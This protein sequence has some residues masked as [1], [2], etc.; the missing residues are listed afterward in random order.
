MRKFESGTATPW[1][2]REASSFF[3]GTLKRSSQIT[4]LAT[5]RFAWLARMVAASVG[6]VVFAVC[7]KAADI[8]RR[9]LSR[10][11]SAVI[12]SWFS[13]RSAPGGLIACACCTACA[14]R[15]ASPFRPLSDV[16]HLDAGLRQQQLELRSDRLRVGRDLLHVAHVVLVGRLLA[17]AAAAIDHEDQQHDDHDEADDEADQAQQRRVVGWRPFRT[18]RGPSERRPAA[19]FLLLGLRLLEKVEIDLAVALAHAASPDDCIAL[20]GS[21]K[22]FPTRR[23]RWRP[24]SSVAAALPRDELVLG[25][26]RPVQPLGSGGSGSVWL[27]RDELEGDEVTLKIVARE[28]KAAAA[29]RARARGRRAARPRALPEGQRLRNGRRPLVHRVRVRARRDVPPRPA[30]RPVGRRNYGGSRRA[31]PRRARARARARHRP[32][33]HQAVEHPARGRRGR[34]LRPPARL[35]PGA[36]RRGRHAH[37]RRRCPRHARLHLAGAPQGPDGRPGR[38]RLGRRRPALGVA[39]RLP[40]VLDIVDAGHGQ[41]D[42][43]RAALARHRAPRS[44]G[45]ADRDRRPGDVPRPAQAPERDADGG[46]RTQ[47]LAEPPARAPPEEAAATP[48]LP[49]AARG[50]H[51][52]RRARRD[53]ER[54][55]RRRRCP[56][57]RPAGPG[58]PPQSPPG[59]RSCATAPG[60]RSRSPCPCSRSAT[61]RW[62]SPSPTSPRR[63]SGW[64]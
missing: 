24:V 49:H 48:A 35:R 45:P 22:D 39:R 6:L 1:T 26:Y 9:P 51:R 10:S 27:A 3:D 32:P 60:S 33:R 47:R 16:G 8:P 42:P 56:S 61:S 13:V 57:S 50:P 55:G 15:C 43:G 28:G 12:I 46:R 59:S 23:P 58:S 14:C 7:A 53:R 34:R 54:L 64:R 63:P 30:R 31:D 38:R 18:A 4:S 19:R 41:E 29:R 11:W 52:R 5:N 62:G 25:R 44:P 17:V 20:A 40:P 2:P 37:G 21:D 36:L